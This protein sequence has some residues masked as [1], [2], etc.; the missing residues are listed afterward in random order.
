MLYQEARYTHCSHYLFPCSEIFIA[1]ALLSQWN[2][3]SLAWLSSGLP[4]SSPTPHHQLPW[5]SRSSQEEGRQWG[6]KRTEIY[7]GP[8]VWCPCS[9]SPQF[10]CWNQPPNVTA[11]GAGASG[12]QLGHEG[13]ALKNGISTIIKEAPEGSLAPF[14]MWGH[15]EK[16][17]LYEP[18]TESHQTSNLLAPWSQ[19]PSLQN[20]G[21][22]M[23]IQVIPSMVFCYSSPKRLR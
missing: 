9:F 16:T 18:G 2:L 13:R 4:A 1:S 12:R 19:T 7:W 14:T 5:A 6:E 8:F 17:A 3:N 10:I 11:L 21:K 22:Q 15:S 20:C 23:F